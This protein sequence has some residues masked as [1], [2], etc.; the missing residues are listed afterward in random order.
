[1]AG[2]GEEPVG[3]G[4]VLT[5]AEYLEQA[6]EAEEQANAVLGG[7]DGKECTYPRGYLTRQAVFVCRTCTP[8]GGAGVCLA[9]ASSCHAGHDVLELWTK[10][11]FRCDCGNSKFGR[12]KCSLMNDARDAVNSDNQYNHNF[13]GLYCTCNRPYPDPDLEEEEEDMLQCCVCEDWFHARHLGFPE[14][15]DMPAYEELVCKG[16]VETRCQFLL[17]YLKFAVLPKDEAAAGLVADSPCKADDCT[18]FEQK[19]PSSVSLTATTADQAVSCSLQQSTAADMSCRTIMFQEG[20]REK[21]C[22][23]DACAKMYADRKLD[24][25]LD[26]QDTWAEYEKKSKAAV[27]ELSAEARGLQAFDAAF[28]RTQK[29]E[30]LHAYHELSDSVKAFLAPFAASGTVVTKADI[31]QFCDGLR[32]HKRQRAH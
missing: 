6:R 10:R 30:L 11:R 29:V 15:E 27:D 22:R 24:F 18:T 20:W 21:L 26:P 13:N 25:L 4:D 12:F 16:C 7:D 2:D 23:C 31:E 32:S 14:D 19:A 9:C 8:E 5:A 1:M 17:H 28:D 3:E